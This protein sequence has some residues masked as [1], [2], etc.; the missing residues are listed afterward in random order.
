MTSLQNANQP[1]RAYPLGR[2]EI[3]FLLT[4]LLIWI[5]LAIFLA[6]RIDRYG[7]YA[8]HSVERGLHFY[9]SKNSLVRP[10]SLRLHK[11]YKEWAL[12]LY[13]TDPSEYT[14]VGLAWADGQGIALKNI[15]PENPDSQSATPYW[16]QAPG[17]GFFI[18]LFI[19]L[20]GRQ[21]IW[22]Y[23][24]FICWLYFSCVTATYLLARQYV[25][26]K[27]AFAAGVLS[28]FCVPVLDYFFGVGVFS[29]DLL[30]AFPISLAFVVASQFWNRLEHI[31]SAPVIFNATALGALFAI[32]S[33]FKDGYV[34]LGIWTLGCLVVCGL[35]QKRPIRKLLIFAGI[36]LLTMLII[37]VP[38]RLR[39][40]S[41]FGQF[42]MCQSTLNGYAL[43]AQT[44]GDPDVYDRWCWNGGTCIGSR[45]A[46]EIAPQIRQE[47]LSLSKESCHDAMRAYIEAVAKHPLAALRFKLRTYS[48]LWLGQNVHTLIYA[49]CLISCIAFL[50]FTVRYRLSFGPVLYTFPSLMLCAS[51]IL[52][53]E[54]RYTLFFY[55][56]ITP[57]AWAV[58]IQGWASRPRRQQSAPVAEKVAVS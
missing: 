28:L 30:A 49:W 58:L 48:T 6:W 3:P 43:W 5:V 22:S 46:P 7:A 31:A 45:L 16:W 50:A 18:G 40:Q 55:Q 23:F 19:K 2:Q 35:I 11:G 4:L 51:L 24:I 29:A 53:Y 14:R 13:G 15:S 12:N 34:T 21:H 27:C 9:Y 36:A 17:T 37:Q 32:A 1:A 33:Y 42:A 10:E 52:H 41:S 26:R 20:F 47:L 44:W 8:S 38:W 56:F 39:N 54:H 57:V 25:D